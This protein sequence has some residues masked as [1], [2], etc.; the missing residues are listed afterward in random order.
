MNLMS[1]MAKTL[2]GSVIA[3]VSVAPAAAERDDL[4]LAG[5]LGRDELDHRRVDLELAQVD[6]GHAELLGEQRGDLLVLDEAELDQIGAQLAAALALVAQRLLELFGRDA[7]LFEEELANPYC[8]VSMSA[9]L[10]PVVPG[11]S[12]TRSRPW[13][14]GA[15][16]VLDFR[17]GAHDCTPVLRVPVPITFSVCRCS[18]CR[19]V[20]PSRRPHGPPHV[21][22]R[23]IGRDADVI[24]LRNASQPPP[25]R[26]SWP[27]P[28][29]AI[30]LGLAP[31]PEVHRSQALEALPT[32]PGGT[33]G[34]ITLWSAADV[35]PPSN[36]PY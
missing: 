13:L 10:R 19:S 1:S 12:F 9:V 29:P 6:R 11:P 26:G 20:R 31:W 27:S 7:L 17:S 32:K 24:G 36:E 4:V 8:H 22:P 21:A 18:P 30:G 34:R 2:V 23:A 15:W 5:G 35:L 28:A 16:P 14:G 33:A 3:I 25:D